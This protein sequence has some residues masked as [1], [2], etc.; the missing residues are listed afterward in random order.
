MTDCRGKDCFPQFSEVPKGRTIRGP[1]GNLRA[2]DGVRRGGTAL[3]IGCGRLAPCECRATR[4]V[5]GGGKPHTEDREK[6]LQ[7]RE[8]C[9]LRANQFHGCSL[10]SARCARAVPFCGMQTN[11][12]AIERRAS[13]HPAEK[14]M[15]IASVAQMSAIVIVCSQRARRFQVCD[16]SSH[17]QKYARREPF[18]ISLLNQEMSRPSS[19][20]IVYVLTQCVKID[21]VAS[22]LCYLR[23]GAFNLS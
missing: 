7:T 22:S 20:Q 14:E 4:V 11:K 13:S 2:A 3:G 15:R 19:P 8:Y 6:G 21:A 10:L 17:P 9:R 5:C 16:L 12:A 18:F 1:G 23:R